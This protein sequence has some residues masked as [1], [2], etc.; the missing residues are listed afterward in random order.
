VPAA[1][2]FTF[3]AVF[4]VVPAIEP[5]VAFPL[6]PLP[7]TPPALLPDAPLLPP[8]PDAPPASNNPVSLPEHAS[9]AQAEPNSDHL[10]SIPIATS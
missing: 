7:E 1:P 9:S 6:V 3:P 4:A 10:R 2:P 8:L 5:P